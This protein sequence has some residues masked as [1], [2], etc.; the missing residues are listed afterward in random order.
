MADFL[1]A[2]FGAGVG[3]SVLGF[4]LRDWLAVRLKSAIDQEALISR[5]IFELKRD[6]CLQTLAVV[7]ASF[8]HQPWKQGDVDVPVVKQPLSIES[9]RTCYNQLA[10]TCSDPELL[11]LYT[12]ALGLGP[13]GAAPRTVSAELLVDLRNAMRTELGFGKPLS[14]PDRTAAWIAYM[15]GA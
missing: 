3:A 2:F 8:S 5:A 9:A 7:D 4:L 14:P 12:K 10:L 13:V 11:D 1:A 6:A 15:E